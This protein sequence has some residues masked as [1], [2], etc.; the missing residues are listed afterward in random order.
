MRIVVALGGNALLKRGEPLTIENQCRN[1][2]IA[3]EALV[4]L[5]RA[6]HQLVITHGNGPQVGLLALQSALTPQTPSPLDVLDAASEGMI[7]YL[8]EQQMMNVLPAGKLT[9]TLL[10]QI[11]VDRDD[12]AFRTPTKPIGPVYTKAEA[13]DLSARRG[14]SIGADGKGWRRLV[15]SPRPQQ[16]LEMRVIEMLVNQGVL[17]ICAGGGGIPVIELEEGS[18]IGVEAVIDKDHAS[19]LLARQLRAD[20]LLMLTDVDAVYADWGKPGAKPIRNAAPQDFAGI[21]LP[22]GSIG[23]KVEAACDFA[24]DTGARAGIGRLQDAV[25]ILAR[26]AGT[27][28]ENKG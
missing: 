2:R 4:P 14:W 10:T 28:I 24:R 12:P 21:D 17:I 26:G 22:A 3:A 6:G 25:A 20:W 15:P 16:I 18:L 7:G 8:I 9:A 5:V 19:A 1:V 11:R 23:P 27:V 13:R